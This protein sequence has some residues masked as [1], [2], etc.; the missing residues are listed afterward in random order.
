MKTSLDDHYR[1][2]PDDELARLTIRQEQDLLP[3]AKEALAAELRRRGMTDLSQYRQAMAE[4]AAIAAPEMKA[5]GTALAVPPQA[6]A[7]ANAN[8]NAGGAAKLGVGV[9][10]G[11]TGGVS[12]G[13]KVGAETK[14]DTKAATSD[15]KSTKA[16]AKLQ[17]KLP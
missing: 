15:S 10:A 11:V 12:A 16:G 6:A 8:A 4:A 3:E 1:L 5:N 17:V 14:A 7:G 9:G 2:L 13:T